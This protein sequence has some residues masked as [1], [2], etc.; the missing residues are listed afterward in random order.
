[1]AEQFEISLR[2]SQRDIEYLRDSMNAPLIYS[3]K[4]R[5]YT[6]SHDYSLPSFFLTENEKNILNTMAENNRRIGSFG[7]S[8]YFKQA[9]ILSKITLNNAVKSSVHIKEPYIAEVQ[10]LSD[11]IS[12]APLDCFAYIRRE[13]NSVLYAFYD[14]NI[15]VSALI[16]S[17]LDFKIIKPKWLKERLKARLNDILLLL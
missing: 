11:R 1:M 2:Q 14:P 6:Y 16:C 7:Y 9:E 5:G 4:E 17:N 13:K 12:T 15:F 3:G 10:L 8:E